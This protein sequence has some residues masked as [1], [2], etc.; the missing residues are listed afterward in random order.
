MVAHTARS[1]TQWQFRARAPRPMRVAS[2][3][4]SD[5]TR[6]LKDYRSW[7]TMYPVDVYDIHVYDDTPWAHADLYARQGAW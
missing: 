6:L 5:T 3:T 1:H 4:V 2:Y 7:R